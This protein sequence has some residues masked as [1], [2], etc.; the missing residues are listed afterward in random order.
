[1]ISFL[2][3]PFIYGGCVGKMTKVDYL[4]FFTLAPIQ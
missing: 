4:L 2:I 3:N 1:M